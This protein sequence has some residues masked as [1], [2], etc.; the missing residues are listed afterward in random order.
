MFPGGP[1]VTESVSLR[2][3]IVLV[4][5]YL[6]LGLKYLQRVANELE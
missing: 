5:K 2:I 1:L 3:H 4:T 6:H